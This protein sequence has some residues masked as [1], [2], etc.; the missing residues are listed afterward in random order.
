MELADIGTDT[1]ALVDVLRNDALLAFQEAY[2][3]A[4]A[5]AACVCASGES[6]E[7][8]ATSGLTPPAATMVFLLSPKRERRRGADYQI[9]GDDDSD[10]DLAHG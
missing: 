6:L 9:P 8:I 3:I 10:A 7:S 4:Y 2:A 5:C 1:V